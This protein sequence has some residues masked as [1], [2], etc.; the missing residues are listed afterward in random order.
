MSTL[1]DECV[2]A[3]EDNQC[4]VTIAIRDGINRL[5][6]DGLV[7]LTEA[8]DELTSESLSY[9]FIVCTHSYP[10]GAAD[11]LSTL[12]C[13]GLLDD[14][15]PVK[16]RNLSAISNATSSQEIAE[17]L[18]KI[19]SK[20]PP[21][22]KA[23]QYFNQLQ[24][25]IQEKSVTLLKFRILQRMTNSTLFTLEM[26]EDELQLAVN[27]A[28]ASRENLF[29]LSHDPEAAIQPLTVDEERRLKKALDHYEPLMQ[30]RGGAEACYEALLKALE[31]RYDQHPIYLENQK[32]RLYLPLEREQFDKLISPC[33]TK[34]NRERA[35]QLYYKNP[36]HC[37]Y[38]FF[39]DIEHPSAWLAGDKH[40]ESFAQYKPLLAM[41]WLAVTDSEMLP[42]DD[43]TFEGR[44]NNFIESFAEFRR[45]HN[46]D[47]RRLGRLG[48]YEFYDDEEGDKPGCL[49]AFRERA[50]DA[51]QGHPL[52][53]MVT[54]RTIQQDVSSRVLNH[55][56]S[57]IETNCDAKALGQAWGR[58]CESGMMVSR[59]NQI[60]AKLNI[61]QKLQR[62]W[63][64]ILKERYV[65]LG[66]SRDLT[67]EYRK[68]FEF[69][70]FFPTHA[71]RF[72]G[73][74][75]LH[76]LLPKNEPSALLT[77]IAGPLFSPKKVLGPQVLQDNDVLPKYGH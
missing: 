37:A 30:A 22:D 7:A 55:F 65:D 46:S 56:R 29:A 47:N 57:R 14:N 2:I 43:Y 28:E 15:Y 42:I 75:E 66:K 8:G 69:T 10:L 25:L 24:L 9:L 50:F 38:R 32:I 52:F 76:Q 45:A 68:M 17:I 41:L 44:V 58:M 63:L 26:F 35:L 11:L 40:W 3:L 71:H 77:T 23:Q 49:L 16:E 19:Y 4:V 48:T 60:L 20:H 61:P 6:E 74:V 54:L 5:I 59:D 1:Y 39:K 12:Q 33:L 27:A 62:K 53:K 64:S 13:F 18:D 72:G 31:V 70:P 67:I 34:E 21:R 36:V 73:V 51:V